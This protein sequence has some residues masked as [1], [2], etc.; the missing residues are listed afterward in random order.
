MPSGHLHQS[1][2]RNFVQEVAIGPEYVNEM[3]APWLQLQCRSG[4]A[5]KDWPKTYAPKHGKLVDEQEEFDASDEAVEM[6]KWTLQG[7]PNLKHVRIDSY[8]KKSDDD[9]WT[10]AWGSRRILRNMGWGASGNWADPSW[11]LRNEGKTC[12]RKLHGRYAKVL[13]ALRGI[14]DRKDWTLEVALHTMRLRYEERPFDSSSS[15]WARV[16]H[17]VTHLKFN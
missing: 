10:E 14:E 15:D 1:C 6:L 12:R 3:L 7:F 17:R 8:P 4:H 16:Q 13:S 11:A 5:D 2:S 9:A